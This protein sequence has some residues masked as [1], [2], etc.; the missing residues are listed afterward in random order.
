[1]SAARASKP[2]LLAAVG[3]SAPT[4][5]SWSSTA[6]QTVRLSGAAGER[7]GAKRRGLV[8]PQLGAGHVPGRPEAAIPPRPAA[9]LHAGDGDAGRGARAQ[10][11][12]D[13]QDPVL[14][15]ADQLLAV[16]EQHATVERVSHRELAHVAGLVHLADL[17]A[18]GQ[19]LVQRDV[20]ADG[21]VQ[22]KQR[23]HGDAAGL[24]RLAQLEGKIERGGH[25]GLLR[26]E[27]FR[28]ERPARR[29]RPYRSTM[30]P[31]WT[32]SSW[33]EGLPGWRR[34]GIC[35]TAT[36]W[37]SRRATGWAAGSARR[38]ATPTG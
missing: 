27:R 35:E 26:R 1:M 17:Q 16:V 30:T 33:A 31:C 25:R 28:G 29:R 38:R 22:R 19:R 24:L 15:G 3:D 32:R 12:R 2:S 8:S 13:V 4:A 7:V 6:A 34:P 18:A 5:F 36:S 11:H 21:I 20:V 10:Q 14:L 23:R 9:A 37:C